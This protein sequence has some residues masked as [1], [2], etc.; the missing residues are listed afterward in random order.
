MIQKNAESL[1]K[2]A[3]CFDKK[4]FYVIN[5]KSPLLL[6]GIS[7][8]ED[9]SHFYSLNLYRKESSFISHFHDHSYMKE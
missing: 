3:F 6:K 7:S 2:N 1:E 9:F 8:S 5:K 4:L